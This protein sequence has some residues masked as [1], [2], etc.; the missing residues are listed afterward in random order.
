MA[1]KFLY[2]VFDVVAQLVSGPVMAL[3]NDAVARRVFQ[4]A[5]LGESSAL[6][7]HPSDYVLLK[8]GALEDEVPVIRSVETT[9]VISGDQ[10]MD[11]QRRAA[12]ESGNSAQIDALDSINRDRGYLSAQG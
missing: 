9:Q 7:R 11:L 12:H 8:I 10:V 6:S 4:D 5:L 2:V 3:P 1:T